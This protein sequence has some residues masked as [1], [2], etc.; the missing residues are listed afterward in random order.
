V[1]STVKINDKPERDKSERKA[2]LGQLALLLAGICMPVLG[3]TLV[4]P[5]LPQMARHFADTPGSEILVPMVLALPA[6]FL[7]L[8]SPFAG[9]FADKV[10]RKRLLLIGMVAYAVVGTAPLYL[11]SLVAIAG[12]RVLLGA[13]EGMIIT[14]CTTLIGDYWSGARRAKYLGLS[15]LVAALSATVFITLGGLLGVSGWRAPFWLYLAPLLF[16]VPMAKLLWQPTRSSTHAAGARL[17][18]LPRRL[19]VPCLV[20]LFGGIVFYA[21]IVELPFVLHEIGL[22]S[23]AAVG[24][25]TAAMSL[26]TAVGAALFAKLSGLSARVLVPLEFAGAAVGLWI[27][28]AAAAV[29]MVAVGAVITGFSTGLL[30][31]TLL[32]WA[33]NRLTYAQR[34]RGTGWWHLALFFGQFVTPLVI[35]GLAAVA[36]G[37][38]PAL[39]ALAVLAAGMGGIVLLMQRGAAEPLA[40]PAA[41]EPLANPASA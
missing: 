38:Q 30:L 25:I 8:T 29:P 10:D 27:V 20:T 1:C 26:A 40:T 17:D 5:V 28:F 32:V 23:T 22:E 3:A 4:A 18:P 39:A 35:A 16:V 21:L 13:C 36:G 7:A 14:C 19:I 9:R 24:G 41:T 33:V 2:G 6:L 15:T 31:P 12:S 34:G 11:D 37:L